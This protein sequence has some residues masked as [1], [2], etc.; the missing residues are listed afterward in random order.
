MIAP[1][2]INDRS[3]HHLHHKTRDITKRSPVYLSLCRC[4]GEKTQ[5]GEQWK[6]FVKHMI[7][8]RVYVIEDWKSSL[9][10]VE[11][12]LYDYG[13]IGPND[14]TDEDFYKVKCDV[15]FKDKKATLSFII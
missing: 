4:D 14:G 11:L 8:E 1:G 9:G 3:T 15:F 10:K 7:K 12:L 5:T 2:V 13:I 6:Y